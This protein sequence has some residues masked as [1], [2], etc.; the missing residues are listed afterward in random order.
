VTR[1]VAIVS[2]RNRPPIASQWQVLRTVRQQMTSLVESGA[3]P[4]AVLV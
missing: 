1:D 4:D 2:G 3:W